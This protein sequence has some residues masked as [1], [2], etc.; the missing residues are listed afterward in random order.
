[1]LLNRPKLEGGGVYIK[2]WAAI[3]VGF[4]AGGK[5]KSGWKRRDLG[6]QVE[7]WHLEKL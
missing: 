1:M 4:V 3:N 5:S 7:H 6:G 2:S